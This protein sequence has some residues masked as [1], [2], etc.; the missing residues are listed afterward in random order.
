[1]QQMITANKRSIVSSVI[2]LSSTCLVFELGSYLCASI[3]VF[4]NV[5]YTS[6]Q[7]LYVGILSPTID[8]D[9]N[10]C[11]VDVNS[12]PKLIECSYAAAKRMKLHWLFTQV[13]TPH[14]AAPQHFQEQ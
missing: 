6:T 13:R 1:M 4:Q 2:V 7:L 10:K 11:L 12:R 5:Y 9:D 8:D 14:H 3:T